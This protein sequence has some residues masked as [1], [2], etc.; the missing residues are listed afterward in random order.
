MVLLTKAWD[1]TGVSFGAGDDTLL[2]LPSFLFWIGGK[3]GELECWT[4]GGLGTAGT[5]RLATWTDGQLYSGTTGRLGF[6]AAGRLVFEATGRPER[7][8]AGGLDSRMTFDSWQRTTHRTHYKIHGHQWE[9]PGNKLI[10]TAGYKYT[11]KGHEQEGPNKGNKDK[12]WTRDW[13]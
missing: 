8:T 5:G 6:W 12:T 9:T 1:H 13:H 3:V 4:T 2:L 11:Q 10:H 7:A